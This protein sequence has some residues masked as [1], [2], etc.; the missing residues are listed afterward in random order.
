MGNYSGINV[1]VCLVFYLIMLIEVIYGIWCWLYFILFIYK[2]RVVFKN[3]FL[4]L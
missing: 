1:G 3:D 4:F 2:N